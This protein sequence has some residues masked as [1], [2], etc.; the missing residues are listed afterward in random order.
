MV[1]IKDIAKECNVSITTVSNVI[2]NKAKV[3]EQT[4][5]KILQVMQERGYRPNTIAQ[6][7][8]SQKTRTIGIIAD[9]VAQFTTPEIIEGI[10]S[11]CENCGYKTTVRNLRMYARWQEGWYYN[12]KAFHSVLD[13]MLEELNSHMVDG[14]IYIA[15]HARKINCFPENFSTPAVMAYAYEINQRVPSVLIDDVVSSREIVQ[16]LIEKGHR[17]I[18][19]IGGREDNIH[20]QRRLAGYREALNRAGIAYDPELI[21]LGNW[22]KD[23][24]YTEI[25]MLLPKGVTAVFCMTDRIAGG[26]YQYLHE[27][28]LVAGKDLSVVGFDNQII[29]EYMIPGLSTMAL[30]LLEIGNTAARLLF[31]QM[32][33]EERKE[34]QGLSESR[35]DAEP[36]EQKEI[37]IPCTFVERES[38]RCPEKAG[39]E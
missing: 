39:N 10:M 18:G 19:V 13:P 27:H 17:K 30:P 24:G 2:N 20:T 3:G 29:A 15:G 4:R 32:E 35:K 1:T 12:E 31:E 5:Q 14:I 25:D 22:E 6:G 34:T 21:Y 38:V 33:E 26:V 11:Y 28:G 8:R 16:Y 36:A 37:L 7:L 23:T 9:D